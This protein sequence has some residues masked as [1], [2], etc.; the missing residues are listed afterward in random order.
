[1]FGRN[2]IMSDQYIQEFCE[3]WRKGSCPKCK[4]ANWLYDSHSQRAY[5]DIRD[6]CR[7]WNCKKIFWMDSKDEFDIRYR[8]YL[9][10]N[11]MDTIMEEYV[12]HHDGRESPSY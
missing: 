10:D 1:M 11:D 9:E 6:G 4:K 7:C 8:D 12:D 5:P 3:F 2:I